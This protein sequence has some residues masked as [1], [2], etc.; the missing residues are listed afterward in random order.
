MTNKI[1]PF[2]GLQNWVRFVKRVTT[3]SV[4]FTAKHQQVPP[5]AVKMQARKISIPN[6]LERL[7]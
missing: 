2:F 7:T 3:D 5:A 1:R 6:L 4:V